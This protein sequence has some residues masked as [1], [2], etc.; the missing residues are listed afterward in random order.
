[1]SAVAILTIVRAFDP[2][3]DRLIGR[4]LDWRSADGAH[5]ARTRDKNRSPGREPC[6]RNPLSNPQSWQHGAAMPLLEGLRVDKPAGHSTGKHSLDSP[7][8]DS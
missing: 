5:A 3:R 2:A 7:E 8:T 6:G 1:M 4:H